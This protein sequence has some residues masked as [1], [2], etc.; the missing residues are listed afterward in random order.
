MSRESPGLTWSLRGTSVAAAAAA[1]HATSAG[2]GT[3]H[4]LA[5]RTSRNADRAS[6]ASALS[7][8]SEHAPPR[9]DPGEEAG[10]RPKDRQTDQKSFVSKSRQADRQTGR[11]A[12]RQTGRQADRQTGGQRHK[13]KRLERLA[14]KQKQAERTRSHNRGGPRHVNVVRSP[15]CMH[16]L[17][18]VGRSVGMCVRCARWLVR[19]PTASRP[20]LE[21]CFDVCSTSP[22]KK[23]P[24]L[25]PPSLPP[26]LQ[27]PP[28]TRA[29]PPSSFSQLALLLYR[30]TE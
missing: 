21:S 3:S 13:I 8:P 10:Q 24:L 12:D 11:Q 26:S 7:L 2:Y 22:C 9:T 30:A 29:A 4:G 17:R 6:T 19:S 15:T 14:S 18:S 25:S 23:A 20:D 1:Q 27:N 16:L 5:S 28:S